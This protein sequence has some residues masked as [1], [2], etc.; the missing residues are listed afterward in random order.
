MFGRLDRSWRPPHHG[1]DE[2][3]SCVSAQE[4]WL[5]SYSRA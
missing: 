1:V 5:L 4:A 3:K 2:R